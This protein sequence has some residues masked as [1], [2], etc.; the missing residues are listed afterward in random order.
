MMNK[1]LVVA[2]KGKEKAVLNLMKCKE[3]K[4]T[5]SQQAHAGRKMTGVQTV[6]GL[7]I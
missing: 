4:Y 3:G 5:Q 1:E 6:L 7:K 2:S